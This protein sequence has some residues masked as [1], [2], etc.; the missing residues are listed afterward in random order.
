[1]ITLRLKDWQGSPA[2]R[3]LI[4]GKKWDPGNRWYFINQADNVGRKYQT[5]VFRRHD[6]DGTYRGYIT[7]RDADH[8]S[9][10]GLVSL[11]KGAC[12]IVFCHKV[13]GFG[14]ADYVQG[15]ASAPFVPI[16][17]F[18]NGDA[19][20]DEANDVLTIRTYP[21]RF[22]T[23]RLSDALRGKVTLLYDYRIPTWLLRFQGHWVA[24]GKLYIHRDK[25]TKGPSEVRSYVLA[26]GKYLRKWNTDPWGDEGEGGME[27]DGWSWSVSRTGGSG[28][29][30]IVTSNQLERVAQPGYPAPSGRDVYVSKLKAGQRNSDSVWHVQR[31][32]GVP[33]TGAYDAATVAAAKAFQRSLGDTVVDGELGPLQTRVLFKRAGINVNIL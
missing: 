25:V 33:R 9:S 4:Q 19:A 21:G 12:R 5:N 6:E 2:G 28:A 22:R 29:S 27:K 24:G 23:Y 15:Q 16:A 11:R 26:T 32:L 31:A 18:P 3:T 30:R 7:F 10:F 8:V 17:G 1:M 20:T 13:K 14:Y